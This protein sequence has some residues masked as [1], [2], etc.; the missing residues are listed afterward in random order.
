M[1]RYD[2][3]APA[4]PFLELQSGTRSGAFSSSFAPSEKQGRAPERLG[5][6]RAAARPRSSRRREA[7]AQRRARR[8]SHSHPGA[9]AA[10]DAS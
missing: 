3:N 2:P 4:A 8:Q 1:G 9:R 10:R 5:G 7:P 6:V